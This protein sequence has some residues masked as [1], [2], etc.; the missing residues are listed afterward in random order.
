MNSTAMYQKMYQK[1]KFT[2]LFSLVVMMSAIN[3]AR[4]DMSDPTQNVLVED[5]IENTWM[6]NEHFRSRIV[7]IDHEDIDNDHDAVL[8][9]QLN[10]GWHTYAEVPGDAGLPPRF[11]WGASENLHEITVIWPEHIKK[12]ELDMFDVNAYIG[13]VDFPLYVEAEDDTK[14]TTLNLD[15]KIMICNEIC[16]PDQVS[17]SFNFP[18]DT[19]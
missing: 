12:R 6:E 17:L 13:D 8:E 4:A 9:I 3:I 5:T 10:D 15:L 19:L 18:A 14:D 11:D 1:I 16:I 2:A 7:A